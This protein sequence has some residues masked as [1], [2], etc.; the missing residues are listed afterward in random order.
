MADDTPERIGRTLGRLF[1]RGRAAVRKAVDPET[2]ERVG[3]AYRVAAERARPTIDAAQRA[4]A[5]RG[6]DIAEVAAQKAVDGAI[7]AIGGRSPLL[8]TTL[9]PLAE[10]ARQEAGRRARDLAGRRPD[11]VVENGSPG[12]PDIV[13][14]TD[15]AEDVEAPPTS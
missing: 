11:A 1:V 12:P 6:P 13:P 10:Q 4:W 2:Q 7:G 15:G 3:N 5:E 9:G 14:A 8:R